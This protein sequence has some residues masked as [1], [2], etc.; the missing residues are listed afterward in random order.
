MQRAPVIR[1]GKPIRYEYIC[2]KCW[3][4]LISNKIYESG[5]MTPEIYVKKALSKCDFKNAKV[6]I[7][8]LNYD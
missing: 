4:V 1:K 6:E 8:D 3:S 2:P 5:A 7:G